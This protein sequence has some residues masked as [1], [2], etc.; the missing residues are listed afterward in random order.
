MIALH[1]AVYSTVLVFLAAVV[2]RGV[3]I[4]K[5]PLHLRWELYPVPHEKGRAHYGGSILEESNWW[6]KPRKKD[7]IGEWKV[8]IPEMLFLKAVWEH[9]RNLW[10]GSFPLH[11]GLY[12]L[13]GNMA[14]VVLTAVL[15]LFGVSSNLLL[16]IIPVIG[17]FG[18][19]LGAFGA[20]LMLLKRIFDRDLSSFSTPS[21]Y[22]NLL[23]MGAIYVTGI[24][25][26]YNDSSFVQNLAGFIA[27]LVAPS[28]TPSLPAIG[29]WHIA[30]T[31]FFAFYLPF[32]HMTHFFIKYFTYHSVRWEDETNRPG[33]PLQKKL[34]PQLA[35]IVTWSAPH[36]GADGRKNWVDIVTSPV[37]KI[38]KENK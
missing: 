1:F 10:Y 24:V 38:K 29:V 22:F 35:Q 7:M 3:R 13:I 25:W 20:V 12:I 4:A 33:D 31:L 30:I 2:K 21:H 37:P 23:V 32:T 16:T 15:Q 19:I 28:L 34:D 6:T 8:M 9:N 5:M 36:I 14:L 17:S 26:I 27:S 18:C 11:F